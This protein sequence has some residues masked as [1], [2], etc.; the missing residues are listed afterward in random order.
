MRVVA[1]HE[2][3][4]KRPMRPRRLLSVLEALVVGERPPEPRLQPHPPRAPHS[5]LRRT[6]V[7]AAGV[8]WQSGRGGGYIEAADI[9]RVALIDT[10]YS[11]TTIMGTVVLY[12]LV[13]DHGGTV[14]LRV[15][16]GGSAAQSSAQSKRA[17]Q[18]LWTPLGVPVTRDTEGLSRPKDHR[19]RWPEAFGVVYAYPFMTATLVAALAAAVWM[20]V[21]VPVLDH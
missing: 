10:V 7:A 14:R 18:E 15:G 6:A 5:G 12:A 16:A 13:I 17:L 1:G 9:A 20:L 3:A 8:T 11:S 21:V 19:R 4:I 2:S